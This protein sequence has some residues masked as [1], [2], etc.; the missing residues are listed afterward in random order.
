VKFAVIG[1]SQMLSM[2]EEEVGNLAVR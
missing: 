2:E 1:G